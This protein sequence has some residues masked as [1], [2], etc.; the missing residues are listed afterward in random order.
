MPNWNGLGYQQLAQTRLSQKADRSQQG[1]MKFVDTM[2]QY[3]QTQ[4]AQQYQTQRDATLQGYATDTQTQVDKA[5]MGRTVAGEEG[6]LARLVAELKDKREQSTIYD[7]DAATKT[8]LEQA[9]IDAMNQGTPK[10]ETVSDFETFLHS[11]A[12]SLKGKYVDDTGQL[13]VG[14]EGILPDMVARMRGAFVTAV[15]GRKDSR[16]LI[17]AFD[18]MAKYTGGNAG[19]GADAAV[20]PKIPDADKRQI[21]LAM[22][23]IVNNGWL[24][25]TDKLKVQTLLRNRRFP[26]AYANEVLRRWENMVNSKG[27]SLSDLRGSGY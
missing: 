14:F 11:A 21:D 18:E 20:I 26:D 4:G 12:R 23:D 1:W 3:F 15:R 22:T 10:D 17:A 25:P 13:F 2:N 7:Q 24:K 9:R 16:D 19:S 8:R 6:A 5:A 27:K